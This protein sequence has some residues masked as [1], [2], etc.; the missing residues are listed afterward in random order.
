[1]PSLRGSFL[2]GT[3]LRAG[4]D[5]ALD[6]PWDRHLPLPVD[7]LPFCKVPGPES[8][9]APR[10]LG[11]WV[12]ATDSRI[13]QARTSL[14]VGA[15]RESEVSMPSDESTCRLAS[16]LVDSVTGIRP[17]SGN[18]VFVY[19]LGSSHRMV[20]RG[21]RAEGEYRGGFLF[22]AAW[23]FIAEVSLLNQRP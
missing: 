23:R 11:R 16:T 6:A 19:H 13:V 17:A 15:L 12:T 5:L 14:G 10:Y 4:T 1:M 20:D 22:D 7:A 9:A 8:E 21:W 18:A 2:F 3:M